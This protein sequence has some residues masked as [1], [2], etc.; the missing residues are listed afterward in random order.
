MTKEGTMVDIIHRVG[1][2]AQPAKVY[3]ALA[4]VEGVAGWW[5]KD[6][7]GESK[8]GGTMTF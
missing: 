6:T 3:A 8:V 4:T 1:I 2:K 7:T 5:T